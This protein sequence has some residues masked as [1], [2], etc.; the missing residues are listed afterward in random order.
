MLSIVFYDNERSL[1]CHSIQYRIWICIVCYFI[2][3]LLNQSRI[4]ESNIRHWELTLTFFNK[5]FRKRTINDIKCSEIEVSG[6][7]AENIFTYTYTKFSVYMEEYKMSAK[8]ENVL[9][10]EWSEK[11]SFGIGCRWKGFL[12]IYYVLIC[13]HIYLWYSILEEYAFHFTYSPIHSYLY[14]HIF[15]Y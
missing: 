10:C 15:I 11:L 5:Y 2:P 4:G 8:R 7:L 1:F 12:Q 14:V 13:T 3:I 6:F 9:L